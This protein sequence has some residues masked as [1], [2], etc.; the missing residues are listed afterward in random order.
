MARLRRSARRRM[1]AWVVTGP[2]GHLY[3]GVADWLSVV[4]AHL[5][6]RARTRARERLRTWLA[7]SR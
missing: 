4:G 3:G 6:A 1:A 2:L 5:L 7:L